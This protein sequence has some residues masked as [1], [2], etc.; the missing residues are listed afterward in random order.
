MAVKRILSTV[1]ASALFSSA[2]FAQVQTTETD[3]RFMPRIYGSTAIVGVDY[4]QGATTTA[5]TVTTTTTPAA[6]QSSPQPVVTYS[7]GTDVVR[8]VEPVTQDFQTTISAPV[9]YSDDGVM[10]A[11]HFKQGDL[12]AAEYQS[13]LDEADRIRAYQV[14]NENYT[15]VSYSATQG[16]VQ[17][18]PVETSYEIEL[19]AVEPAP[20]ADTI[21]YADTTTVTS[22]S[23]P[24]ALTSHVVSKGDTLY[25]ISKRY[26][27]TVGALQTV[28]NLNGNNIGL[29]QVLTI[30]SSATIISEN[31]YVAPLTM[32]STVAPV[33]LVRNVEPVP[34]QSSGVYAVLPKDTLYSISR[35]A[36]VKVG[37]LIAANGIT[38]PNALQPGQRLTM[39]AGHCLN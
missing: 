19:F 35:R 16:A 20:L 8:V 18:A 13:L 28:N 34:G 36:C 5:G 39:P 17:S 14:T 31:T 9:T 23:A 26:A 6:T 1:A 12:S 11:Q 4:G 21:T 32:V 15:G 37:D 38:N 2:A 22:F 29:G 7:Q 27:V 10:K 33:T 25:N 30:P 3:P 24:A